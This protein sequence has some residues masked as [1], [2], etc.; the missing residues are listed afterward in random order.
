MAA[1]YVLSELCPFQ[2]SVSDALLAALSNTQ[3]ALLKYQ[4]TNEAPT[5]I[6]Q[7]HISVLVNR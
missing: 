6:A 2:K 4:D 1:G 5:V 3:S 7:E